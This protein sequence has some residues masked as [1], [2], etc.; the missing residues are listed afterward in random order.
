[1]LDIGRKAEAQTEKQLVAGLAEWKR[2]YTHS[3]SFDILKYL[4]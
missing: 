1:M 4:F 3:S 2:D